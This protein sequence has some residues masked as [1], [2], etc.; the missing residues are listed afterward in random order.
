M[1]RSD[2]WRQ[3]AN[4]ATR[5][6][7]D[8]H[9]QPRPRSPTRH[10][11]PLRVKNLFG[12]G[13]KSERRGEERGKFCSFDNLFAVGLRGF[14]ASPPLCVSV[15]PPS[16]SLQHPLSSHRQGRSFSVSAH[17]PLGQHYLESTDTE[18]IERAEGSS[19]FRALLKGFTGLS[20]VRGRGKT[21]RQS[22]FNYAFKH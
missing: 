1:D 4:S 6:K 17:I 14:S 3:L 11:T 5:S 19:F 2:D 7:T 10:V 9:R 13:W 8:K 18:L 12:S 16:P 20:P 21:V 15:C 22:R